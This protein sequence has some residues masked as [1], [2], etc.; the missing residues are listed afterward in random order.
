MK[1]N[2]IYNSDTKRILLI[3]DN[4]DD[5]ELTIMALRTKN[6]VNEIDVV[7]DGIEA[8]EY[9]FYRGKYKDRSSNNPILILLDL[10][11]PKINGLE[12]LKHLRE[13]KDTNM[14]PITI[15]TSSKE[16]NDII[17]SYNI[18]AS[19]FVRKPVDA[20]NFNEAIEQLGLYWLLLNEAPSSK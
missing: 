15:F 5:I 14:I 16:E 9:L 3:E 7:H 4:E 17:K 19:S 2:K 18:G 13:N 20:D 12:V 6:I 8:L 1:E 11:L 10:Q